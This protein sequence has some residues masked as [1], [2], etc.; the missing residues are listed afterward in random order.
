MFKN[1]SHN[2]I[3]SVFLISEFFYVSAGICFLLYF[4]C[5]QDEQYVMDSIERVMAELNGEKVEEKCQSPIFDSVDV[6]NEISPDPEPVSVKRTI[7]LPT[8]REAG[9]GVNSVLRKMMDSL[10]FSESIEPEIE[11]APLL[12]KV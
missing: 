12:V 10:K 11:A 4:T 9:K 2:R 5:V 3:D 1:R 8:L 7:S 6:Y